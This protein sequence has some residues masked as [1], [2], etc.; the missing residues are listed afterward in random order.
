VTA[1]TTDDLT[2]AQIGQLAHL[3]RAMDNMS[4]RELMDMLVTIFHWIRPASRGSALDDAFRI[5]T[6][7]VST[8][9]RPGR[10]TQ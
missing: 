4:D 1:L 2:N 3:T 10:S 7:T 6:R 5:A 8:E 9:T